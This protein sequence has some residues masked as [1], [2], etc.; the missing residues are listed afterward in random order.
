MTAPHRI[1]FLASQTDEAQAALHRLEG[2]HGHYEPD[3]ADA[4]TSANPSTA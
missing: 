4:A 2:A 3:A 1:A